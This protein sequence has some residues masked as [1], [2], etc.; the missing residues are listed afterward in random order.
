MEFFKLM[1]VVTPFVLLLAVSATG[2]LF[3]YARLKA[4]AKKR[5]LKS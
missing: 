4:N 5:Q 2:A 3:L 1:L